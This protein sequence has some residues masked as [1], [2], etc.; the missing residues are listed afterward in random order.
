MKN[1][2]RSAKLNELGF[3]GRGK[4]RHRPRND[5]ILYGGAYPFFQTGDVKSADLYLHRCSA[6]YNEIGL[7]QSKLWEPGTLC[8]TIAA[9]IAD[10]AILSVRGCFP[11]SVVGF[12][13]DTGKADTKYIKYVLDTLKFSMESVARG[14]TQDNLSLEKLLS[15]DFWIPNISLQQRIAS[16]LSAY[17][18][19]IEN[20]TRRI[21]ILEEM[22]RR[23]YEEWFVHY[24]IPD[25]LNAEESWDE[26]ALS[27]MIDLDKGVSYKGKFLSDSGLTMINLKNFDRKGGFRRDGYKYYV[28][29]VKA[30]HYVQSRDIVLANTDLTQAG[31]IV[32]SPALVPRRTPTSAAIISHHVFA[33]RLR[34]SFCREYLYFYYMLSSESFKNFARGQASGTT[35]LGLH[36]QSVQNYRF[37]M[38]PLSVRRSFHRLVKPISEQIEVLSEINENVREQR[39]MLLPKLITGELDVSEA[40]KRLEEAAA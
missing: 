16:I 21:A 25:T 29:D 28:G 20:N 24:Q 7:A 12:V 27:D 23:F 38:A 32:G 5:P 35:V 26:I 6:T 37:L 1:R 9:N 4:S 8:I 13:A 33:V 14:T 36:R 34:K 17:D 19:L 11:D 15:F 22:A 31:E 10:S 18:D 2:W 39:D 3:V 40:E 30:R